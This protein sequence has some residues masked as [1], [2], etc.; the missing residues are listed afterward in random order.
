MKK[1][2]PSSHRL[3]ARRRL[4]PEAL[5]PERFRQDG[6]ID[7][8]AEMKI[9]ATALWVGIK[10]QGAFLIAALAGLGL[11]FVRPDQWS[12]LHAFLARLP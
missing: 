4:R 11:L 5:Y 9:T 3:A 6:L 1:L 7:R 10:M 2:T 12:A 8:E